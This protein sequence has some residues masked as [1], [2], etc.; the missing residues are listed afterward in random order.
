M[1]LKSY[2]G[3]QSYET[4]FRWARVALYV[5]IGLIL[6]CMQKLYGYGWAGETFK[7]KL[8]AIIMFLC[9]ALLALP[10]GLAYYYYKSRRGDD[11]TRAL[12]VETLAK[13]GE[14]SL[15]QAAQADDHKPSTDKMVQ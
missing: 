4:K 9:L 1:S 8:W 11:I 12:E 6:L 2:L 14:A 3:R 5:S 13:V 7:L 15:K 10:T